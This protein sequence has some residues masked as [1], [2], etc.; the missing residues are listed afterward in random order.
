MGVSPMVDSTI[1]WFS[2]TTI[3]PKSSQT[4]GKGVAEDTK[5]SA[6]L[7]PSPHIPVVSADDAAQTTVDAPPLSL[8]ELYK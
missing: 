8:S 3:L 4:A 2:F 7:C 5:C 6:T 1:A